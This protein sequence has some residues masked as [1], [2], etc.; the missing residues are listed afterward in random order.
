MLLAEAR[1][2][3]RVS[4]GRYL[5]LDAISATHASTDDA[6]HGL[7]EEARTAYGWATELAGNAAERAYLTRRRSELDAVEGPTSI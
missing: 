2:A 4:P 6:R 5:T 3:V 1:S 7:V